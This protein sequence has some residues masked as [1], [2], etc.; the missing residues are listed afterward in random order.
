MVAY[1]V[2][3]LRTPKRDLFDSLGCARASVAEA[4]FQS[5]TPVRW[6]RRG[7]KKEYCS[8][9]AIQSRPHLTRPL[10]TAFS[11][12]PAVGPFFLRSSVLL[13]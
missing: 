5:S 9:D 4:M 12:K 1:H 6:G 3:I 13:Q 8:V 11:D 7:R 10:H 2:H